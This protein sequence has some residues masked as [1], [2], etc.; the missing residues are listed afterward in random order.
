MNVK[1]LEE[2]LEHF[3]QKVGNKVGIRLLSDDFS[4][5]GTKVVSLLH[6]KPN[7]LPKNIMHGNLAR[8]IR[9]AHRKGVRVE[10][11]GREGLKEFMAIYE[12]R[13]HQL[14]S[15]NLPIKFFE[16]L[17]QSYPDRALDAEAM[18]HTAHY[19]GKCVGAAFSLRLGAW[20]ENGWFA[21]DISD[22]SLYVAYSLHD[23]MIREAMAAGADVYSFG[24]STTGSGVHRFKQ[25][26]GTNELPVVIYR[27]PPIRHDL[28]NHPWLHNIW[29]KAPLPIAR[30]F[31]PYL[32][33]WL[34]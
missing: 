16:A 7:E 4:R 21:T 10:R 25:Q 34:Y 19:K 24:R 33:K 32:S 22:P 30:P 29:K 9:V 6:L 3:Q 18:L 26:W 28:R 27:I 23:A 17:L 8:K 11:Q 1:M 2:A 5:P 15:A 12:R 31:N 20:F 13:L 14:G